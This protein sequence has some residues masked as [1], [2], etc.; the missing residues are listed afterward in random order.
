MPFLWTEEQEQAF[1][2][3]RERL[4]KAPVLAHFDDDAE[5]EIHTDASNIGLGAVLVQ[6]QDGMERVIAYASRS[7]TK[8]EANYSTTEKECLAVVWAIS[9]FRPYLY[10]RPFRAV[11]DHHSL[12]WLAN[13]RDPSGRL[14]RWSLRL[15]EY[16]ITVVYRSGRKHSDADCLSRAPIPLTSSDLEQ[17]LPFL[18]VVD[19]VRMADLQRADTDLLALI[20][21]LQ[22]AD[23][24]IPRPLSRGLT[25]YCLR[26]NVLYKKNFENSQETFLLVVPTALR[27]E[28]LQACHDDPCAGHLG[29]TRTLARIRQ[30]YYWPR[31]F[32]S[33]Q[34]YVKTCRDCQRRKVPPVKPAGLLQPLEPP[35]APFQQ[36]GMDLLGPFPTSSAENKWIIVATDYL[37]RYAETKAVP[38]AT[39][40]EVAKFFVLN[41]VLRHGAPAVLI[42]DR[43]AAFTAD[44][45]QEVVTLT[46]SNHRKTTAYHPQTNGL[47]ERL[48]RTLAD[49]LSMYVDVEHKTWDEILP[50]VTFAYNTAVQETTQLTPFELVYGRRVT[51]PLDAMLP[52][53]DGTTTSEGADDFI[54]KAEEARQLAR[55]RIRSQQS[56]DAR[57]YNQSR[58]NVQYNPG[59]HVWVWTPVRHRGLSEKLLR[60]Y[61]GPYEVVRRLSDVNYEIL[62][63]SV[64]P[65]LSRRRPRPE[66]VHVVRMKPYYT[67]E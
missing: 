13:L 31:L 49:M 17:D 26:N 19:T 16:D 33:V 12:C 34:H 41:I 52:V 47:T 56:T 11:S 18:G 6:W 66:V 4:Q 23:V 30:R 45:I 36:V 59:D 48:N 35:P 32:S 25:S 61:F 24:V 51:T 65:R 64:D 20:Q 28:V 39:A 29:F 60:R 9:K 10:G 22:G 55:N 3:L 21:Y 5:T 63:Q 40:A 62:P 67:R 57:R 8:A 37:T 50:Y 43:G 38:R 2:E 46:H 54:Q 14:A 53:D 15:Q 7:L 44:L 42:T 1:T 27:Q 58:R